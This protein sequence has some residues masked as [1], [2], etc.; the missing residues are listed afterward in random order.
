MVVIQSMFIYMDTIME[1]Q[2]KH[3]NHIKLKILINLAVQIFKNA[4]IARLLLEQSQEIK[5]IV[6]LKLNTQ[7]G[8]FLNMV[9]FQELTK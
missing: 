8:K 9:V 7:F 1:S 2:N 4:Q 5:E 3:V 6:G